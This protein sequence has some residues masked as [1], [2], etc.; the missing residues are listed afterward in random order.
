VILASIALMM[1]V[2]STS[3]TSDDTGVS[4]NRKQKIS[5]KIHQHY[6]VFL[7]FGAIVLIN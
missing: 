1:V 2:E 3:E 7:L 4:C 5:W 6:I